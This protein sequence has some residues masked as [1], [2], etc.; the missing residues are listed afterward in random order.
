MVAA[1]A[2]M[3][4]TPR[5]AAA[6]RGAE[7]AGIT[8]ATAI[9]GLTTAATEHVT[10]TAATTA[11]TRARMTRVGERRDWICLPQ[12]RLRQVMN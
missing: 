3:A 6:V 1:A 12:H 7:D 8:T 2:Q 4:A 5:I 9:E 11:K 10:T